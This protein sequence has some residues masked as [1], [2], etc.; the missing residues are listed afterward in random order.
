MN[1]C[2]NCGH[3]IS[4]NYCSNCGQKASGERITFKMVLSDFVQ[5]VFLFDSSLYTTLKGLLTQPGKLIQSFMAGKRK[6][7][8]PVFQYFLL[9]MTI[10]LIALK[11]L[12]DNIFS[13]LNSGFGPD[14]ST[15]PDSETLNKAMMVQVLVRKN[16]NILYFILT[17]ILAFFIRVFF[18]KARFNYAETLIFSLYVIGT[19]FLLSTVIVLFCL[20][21]VKLYALRILIIFVYFPFAIIGFTNSKLPAG[22]IKSLLTILSSYLVFITFIS[23]TILLY[24]F[25]IMN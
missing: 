23:V 9:F 4:G 10:Y 20:I 8:L 1:K 22:I 14:S 21:N 5:A 18:R 6:N 11:F 19:N 25:L 24:V 13:Y 12:G 2:L 15:V 3:E 17:P 16:L 7:Y